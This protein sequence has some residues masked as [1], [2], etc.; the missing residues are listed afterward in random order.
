MVNDRFLSPVLVQMAVYSAIDATERTV[1]ASSFRVQG[2]IEFE[3]PSPPI[4]L[5]NMFAGDTGSA[6]QV[7]LSAAVPLAYVLQGGFQALQLKKVA[8]HIG[9]FDQK[10]Q[11]QIDQ[12]IAGRRV[13][14][15]GENV[16]LTILL[17]G[18]N[19][20]EV[21]RQVAFTVPPGATPG[22]LFF[23]VADGN[24]TNMAEFRQ[25]VGLPARSAAQLVSTVN[26]LRANTKAYVRVWR[27]EP[28]FQLEGDDLPDP[29]A[30]VSLILSAAQ[31][32]LAGISQTRNSKMAEL[33]VS[34][35]E[36]VITGSK[37]IQLEVKE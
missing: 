33:E 24:T 16:E 10:K 5:N 22:P 13:V 6:L 11:L 30:S 23:T 25:I 26:N 1:G 17:A 12:V 18:E 3:G 14:R 19:G 21:T 31:A 4:K 35:G 8:V 20:Q 15:P 27:S 28:A 29:P 9:S 34:A 37:T 32:A 2:Q 7:S 36:M